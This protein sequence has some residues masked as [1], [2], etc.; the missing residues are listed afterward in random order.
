M[1]GKRIADAFSRARARGRA[2]FIPYLT[3]G[4]PDLAWTGRYLDRLTASG[5]DILELGVPFSDPI[6]DGPVNQRSSERALRARTTLSGILDLVRR[7]REAGFETPVVLFSYFNPILRM[8]VD[9]FA[10]AAARAGVDG[11]LV[12]DLPPEEGKD[13]RASLAAA[14]LDTIFLASP[15]TS[16]ERLERI[17]ASSTGFVYY[18]SR[19]GVTGTRTALADSL[20]ADLERARRKIVKPLAVGFG[21]S[22]PEQAA[23]VAAMADGVVVGSALVKLLEGPDPE[24]A[25]DALEKTA[26]ELIAALGK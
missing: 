6:A 7:K 18:V 24:K 4:D 12:V 2:A 21:I 22:T 15:T 26:A 19:L 11:V 16:A 13:Y 20:A 3:A 10:G 9:R 25:A 23:A 14:G 5:A 17:D 1:A 8:G